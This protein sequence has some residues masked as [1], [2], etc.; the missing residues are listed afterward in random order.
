MRAGDLRHSIS[1]YSKAVGKDQYGAAT[2][3]YTLLFSVRAKIRYLRGDEIL[4]SSTTA[5]TTVMQ[6]IIRQR[7]DISEEMEIE[8]EGAR[9][10]IQIIEVAE[11]STMMK[12]TGTKIVN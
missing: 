8:Y 1:F 5:N 6:F 9:Y 10:N 11:R 3:S 2:E 12:I 4:L 7:S